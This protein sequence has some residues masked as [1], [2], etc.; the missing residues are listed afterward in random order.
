MKPLIIAN[1]KMNPETLHEAQELLD[2]IGKGVHDLRDVDVVVCPPFLYLPMFQVSSFKFQVGAQDC[3]WENPPAGGGAFTG[4]ISSRMLKDLGCSYVIVGH[5]ER[6]KYMAET[7]EMINK[8]MLAVLQARLT[9]IICIGEKERGENKGEL[10]KQMR[11]ILVKINDEDV[12]RL[13]LAYEPEWAISSNTNAQSAR[14]DDCKSS[15]DF[16]RAV[17]SDMFGEAKAEKVRIL[18]GG[19]TNSK[20]ISEFIKQ[21]GAQGALVGSSSLDEKEFVSL[22][23][24]A[25]VR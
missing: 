1:W 17:L 14:P 8:K 3:F 5:S 10:E 4:E 25:I 15:I 7:Y 23:K 21:G 6:K 22:V 20:N 12:A 2:A 24:N 11:E 13:V 9:P 18:Y 16:M 19:S